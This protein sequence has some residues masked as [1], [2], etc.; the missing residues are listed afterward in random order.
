LAIL[1]AHLVDRQAR[2]HRAL[3]SGVT[4][5]EVATEAGHDHSYV[6]RA[7]RGLRTLNEEVAAAAD[8]LWRVQV[9]QALVELGVRWQREAGT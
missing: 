6:S 7:A 4:V 9:A 3:A 1:E 8:R 5:R 2:L